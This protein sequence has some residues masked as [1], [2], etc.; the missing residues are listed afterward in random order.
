MKL[1]VF[2]PTQV[3]LEQEVAHVTVEDVTGSLGVRP[4][5]APLVT[6]LVPGIVTAR[7]ATERERYVAVDGGVMTVA[8][9]AVDVVSRQAVA[10]D[11]LDHLETTVLAGFEQA[12][13][14]AR[15]NRA[16]FEKMRVR[17]MRGILDYDRAD[18]S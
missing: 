15:A 9:N 4:G 6:A 7:D 8:G 18:V 14:G 16:A 17:F 10:S 13:A 12:V 5:H 3:V 1:R 2:T 11:D